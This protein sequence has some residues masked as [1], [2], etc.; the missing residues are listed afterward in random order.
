MFQSGSEGGF[1]SFKMPVVGRLGKHVRW[2]IWGRGLGWSRVGV[3]EAERVNKRVLNSS[4]G[5]VGSR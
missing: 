5:S 1:S 3:Q 4:G 2:L